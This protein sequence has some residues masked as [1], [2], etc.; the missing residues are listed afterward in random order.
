[1]D[2][3]ES[4]FLDPSS[5]MAAI[6]KHKV[7]AIK[8]AREQGMAVREMCR[9]AKTEVPEYEFEELI[10]KGAYGRV[11][12]GHQTSSGRVVAIKV[13][14]I[15]S[16][17]YN[18]FRDQK[19]ESI[20]E[21][22]HETTVMKQVKDSGAQNI[23]ELIEA[24]S[25]HSQLWLVCEYCP[26]GSVRTLMRATNDKLDE[27][28]IIPIA[29]ELAVGLR[30]IHGA[31][32]IHRDIKAANVLV[33]E[34]GHLEI[35]DFGVAGVLQS[36]R[37]KRSTWIGTPHFMPPEM[38][39]PRA[40]AHR[41][42][43]EVDVWAYGCTLFEFANGTPPNAGLRDRMHIGRQLTRKTPQLEKD[44]YSQGLK[45]LITFALDPNPVTRP[46]MEDI[47]AHPY[48]M[49]TEEEYPTSSVRELVKNY[50]QWSQ[51]GGQR[52]SL[53]QAGGAAA[54]E[55]P[56]A[57]ESNDDWNF[58][59]TD[60]FERRFSVI[61]M[62]QIAATLAQ[63]EEP[64]SP[65]SQ[66]PEPDMNEEFSEDALSPE[67]KLNFDERVRRGA[68]AMEGL[69]DEE[70]PSYK[71]E[72]KR[73]FV[74]LEVAQ[75]ISDLPLRSETDRSSVTSTFLDID[76][77]SFE[78]SHYAAGAP[79]AQPFQLVDANTIRATR[80]SIRPHRNSN[81]DSPRSSDDSVGDNS[82]YTTALEDTFVPSGPRP[83]TMDW[84]FPSFGPPEDTP[85][86]EEEESPTQPPAE[87]DTIRAEKRATMQWTFPVMGSVPESQAYEDRH[88]TLRAP[89][90]T[91][92]EAVSSPPQANDE[93]GEARPS[94]SA[95]NTS[96]SDY[97]I[98]ASNDLDY[99]PFRFD[100][101]GTPP[102]TSSLQHA[103]F[104][105]TKVPIMIRQY[106][107]EY[108][109][110]VMLDG[111]G[112]DEEDQPVWRD[113]PGPFSPDDST[114]PS[115]GT[116][117][118]TGKT[119]DSATTVGSFKT[120]LPTA[121]SSPGTPT[122]SSV[123]SGPVSE[124]GSPVFDTVRHH[125]A[126]SYSEPPMELPHF[127]N[128]SYIDT[129]M[130]SQGGK[131]A[132]P[133]P[134]LIP[135]SSASLTEGVD[136][137]VVAAE[138]D[139][140][141]AD[142]LE[143]LEATGEA[144]VRYEPHQDANGGLQ[145]VEET[146]YA[147]SALESS[148]VPEEVPFSSIPFSPPTNHE[149]WKL[150]LVE[151]KWFCL[152]QQ[153]KLCYSRCNQ[154]IETAMDP[155][156][157]I[158]ATYLHYYAATS[159]E[160]LGRAAHIFSNA[161]VPL[162]T[163][164]VENFEASLA[165]LPALLPQPV[166]NPHRSYSPLSDNPYSR[167]PSP[168]STL[169]PLGSD[170]SPSLPTLCDD[171]PQPDTEVDSPSCRIWS[172]LTYSPVLAP[173]PSTPVKK[174]SHQPD[175]P[176]QTPKSSR[177]VCPCFTPLS[178]STSVATAFCV[179]PSLS[180]GKVSR[181]AYDPRTVVF[182]IPPPT[183]APPP[184]PHE[185]PSSPSVA[186]KLVAFDSEDNG[187]PVG[188]NIVRNIARMINNSTLDGSNDPFM[189]SSEQEQEQQL[190]LRLPM[191]PPVRLSPIKFPAEFQDT[192]K[193]MKLLPSPLQIRK[194]SGDVF[195]CG[196]PG[197]VIRKGSEE[198]NPEVETTVK[199]PI[200]SRPP[201]LP[202]KIIPAN[203]Q[204]ANKEKTAPVLAPQPK[205]VS[206]PASPLTSMLLATPT[207]VLK[208]NC[209]SNLDPLFPTPS[210][211][212]TTSSLSPYSSLDSPDEAAMAARAAH[213]TRFNGAVTWLSEHIPEDL[214]NLRK[215][216]QHVTDLQKAR[217]GRN[218]KMS[219]SVSFWTFSP[220][221]DKSKAET[222]ESAVVDGPNIDEYGNVLRVETKAQRI[223]RLRKEGWRI[224]I[225]S[226]HSLWKG[227]EYYDR[228]CETALGELGDS[229]GLTVEGHA[230]L[231]KW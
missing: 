187:F 95:S 89:L 209:F 52:Q 160:Y 146:L 161:K 169:S 155:L 204:T 130:V 120:V 159:Y 8:L 7:D 143:S 207:P 141:L 226:Q 83:P 116:I 92:S 228:L 35:C 194:T 229:R 118:S 163:S 148:V 98:A 173:S 124:P 200:R 88:D 192:A 171:D 18:A 2:S 138:F 96:D 180:S 197:V 22:I 70:K 201:R 149:E 203:N 16:L 3:R 29:R 106:G 1:M 129:H 121:G 12:K 110:S 219:R 15:D 208:P 91:L 30:A 216:I 176:F 45:D 139:R 93:P 162:L 100:R 166:L 186:D 65:T 225:R 224:G 153:Y 212:P 158:R 206:P 48:I 94:T 80:S 44:G 97:N 123:T 77:G 13:M 190:T 136:D 47:L 17:D 193:Q 31:G 199:R 62:D 6:T 177:T 10:G 66:S 137:G 63:M 175:G 213:V 128:D 109:A 105:D 61:D 195:K 126:E 5:A 21:F 42:G 217:N 222:E 60:G 152:N 202:L 43:S 147:M 19:D 170:W 196:G 117:P 108:N 79:A 9:R 167:S 78:A 122:A 24:I 134:S 55:L 32:I 165:A 25:I 34:E 84:K 101:P 71:Y 49:D 183:R 198:P 211:E 218:H 125:R 174:T 37:D 85:P 220:V 68:E 107:Y 184:P 72:T 178:D 27:K 115:T 64:L 164:A 154:L 59:T 181:P 205:C 4:A 58:S 210:P 191:R 56:D 41:Y 179:T 39:A 81:D 221:K 214:N 23:N 227:T 38:Y 20:K 168:R 69:F 76:I 111:P 40:E 215:Q 151:V 99:D 26:G 133:F 142:L 114:A 46:T 131:G 188:G 51:R 156:N 53:F 103:H 11:Y 86:E 104:W 132:I 87:E 230:Y 50:Y 74:P 54:A 28:Y 145:D 185:E 127:R 82:S 223:V 144:L 157:P 150:A 189:S 112:P 140:L 90:P 75:P 113:Y 33:H 172:P 36:Q 231:K 73:D 102:G 14:D 67:D 135:P 57:E 119:I 182:D